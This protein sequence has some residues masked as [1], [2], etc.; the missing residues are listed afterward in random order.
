MENSQLELEKTRDALSNQGDAPDSST[1]NN[2]TSSSH[3]TRSMTTLTQENAKL[4]QENAQFSQAN[5]QL[6]QQCQSQ[7]AQNQHVQ[8]QFAACQQR[9]REVENM[10]T[11]LQ[12]ENAS[13]KRSNEELSYNYM[14]VTKSGQMPS[15][16][17]N[18][19]N[20]TATSSGIFSSGSKQSTASG[21]LLKQP[22]GILDSYRAKFTSTNINANSLEQST[23]NITPVKPLDNEDAM[24]ASDSQDA[25]KH[26]TQPNITSSIVATSSNCLTVPKAPEFQQSQFGVCKPVG[27][28]RDLNQRMK[29][30]EVSIKKARSGSNLYGYSDPNTTVVKKTYNDFQDESETSETSDDSDDD[31]SDDDTLRDYAYD[32]YDQYG[33]EDYEDHEQF[34]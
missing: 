25:A 32:Y 28:L 8:Q 16:I 31:T 29:Q 2:N 11:A 19:L 34:G 3:N 15:Q 27:N 14:K 33:Y 21:G 22:Q 13:L 18:V 6:S 9:L 10:Y 20:S 23:R 12:T 17:S 30:V 26:N 1:N 24:M 7:H 4:R 5:Q